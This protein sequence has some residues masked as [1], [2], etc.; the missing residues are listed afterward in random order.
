MFIYNSQL[1]LNIHL[2]A[3]YFLSYNS[4][5]SIGIIFL[6]HG[7]FKSFDLPQTD[8]HKEIKQALNLILNS[9]SLLGKTMHRLKDI[10]NTA[11]L[12]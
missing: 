12:L 3:N 6:M 8:L 2:R 10:N 4:F 1:K 11:L 5:H 9:C 7:L